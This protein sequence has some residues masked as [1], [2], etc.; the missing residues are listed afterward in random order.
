MLSFR[1]LSRIRQDLE[2]RSMLGLR[3]VANDRE[4]LI[5]GANLTGFALACAL[6]AQGVR[7]RV[8][9]PA[10]DPTPDDLVYLHPMSLERLDSLGVLPRVLAHGR[11]I[12]AIN[13]YTS[14]RRMARIPLRLLK[15]PFPYLLALPASAVLTALREHAMGQ[16]TAVT[17]DVELADLS[18]HDGCIRATGRTHTGRAQSIRGR[19][20]LDCTSQVNSDSP[21][22]CYFD[23]TIE[24]DFPDDERYV[25]VHAGKLCT[26]Q[27]HP[28]PAPRHRVTMF[29]H[30]A[31][32]TTGHTTGRM[33]G[34]APS[35]VDRQGPDRSRGGCLP[36]QLA[37]ASIPFAC[38]LREVGELRPIYAISKQSAG[39]GPVFR[40]GHG[41]QTPGLFRFDGVN[42][43]IL[44]AFNLA[45]KLGLTK[46][47]FARPHLLA[48]YGVESALEPP[49][50]DSN[51]L[52]AAFV[53]MQDRPHRNLRDALAGLGRVFEGPHRAA[54]TALHR[55]DP[56]LCESP[57]V[58]EVHTPLL[59]SRL[60]SS[61]TT[62][63]A[64]LRER[65]LFA[66]APQAGTRAPDVTIAA[67]KTLY[68][69]LRGPLH[70]LLLFDGHAPTAAGYRN[71]VEIARTIGARYG[72][73]IRI[74]IIVPMARLPSALAQ[75]RERWRGDVIFDQDSKLHREY[76]ASAECLYLIRPDGFIGFR[77]QPAEQST[78]L[79]HIR[80]ILI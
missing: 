8:F 34:Q 1:A 80:G 76:G 39:E 20:Y 71:F 52:D 68:E 60:R 53:Q 40:V 74:H 26:V 22:A 49:G 48:S 25:F 19:W 15:T 45:W 29:G 28:G 9:A 14:E 75:Q 77:S 54:F 36:E 67:Q 63:T 78:L 32:Y 33:P 18:H 65:R 58:D 30:P 42:A 21:T 23:A 24:W 11:P 79:E 56:N 61:E 41:W 4:A 3:Q 16:G 57:L 47:G 12:H 31:T 64:S 37:Q 35:P 62:E 38:N 66:A 51:R 5:V 43:G 6:G 10:S 73:L 2:Q 70:A 17:E 72:D 44:A 7:N 13:V 27:A 69:S 50:A 55:L 59:R 46:R